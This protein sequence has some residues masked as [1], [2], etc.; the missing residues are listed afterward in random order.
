[1]HAEAH[2]IHCYSHE[3]NY[4]EMYKK[5]KGLCEDL[6]TDATGIDEKTCECDFYMSIK[7]EV[8]NYV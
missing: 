2:F 4:Y 5:T 3:L 8:R 6:D 1:M 7:T